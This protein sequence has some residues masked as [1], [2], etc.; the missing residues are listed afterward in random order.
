LHGGPV[1]GVMLMGNLLSATHLEWHMWAGRGYA[2]FVPDYRSSA[3]FGWEY[4]ESARKRQ[5]AHDQDMKDILSGVDH[6]VGMG[7]VD[8]KRMVL[9]GQSF[10]STLTNWIL[11]KD[12]RFRVAVSKEGTIESHLAYGTGARVGGNSI[13][14]WYCNGTPWEVPQNYRANSAM[15]ELHKSRTPTLLVSGGHGIPLY[16]NEFFYTILRKQNVPVEFV[17]YT[18]EGHGIERPENQ[19]DLL[20][21]VLNFVET[22]LGMKNPGSTTH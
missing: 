4:I 15:W 19:R 16:H 6:V 11:P 12:H 20:Y 22:H 2:V 3:I 13:T 1:G 21:R 5:D 7:L 18:N 8:Q 10:G 9:I 14:E 17:V